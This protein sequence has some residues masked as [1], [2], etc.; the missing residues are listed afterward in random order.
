[1]NLITFI[2]EVLDFVFES[3]LFFSAMVFVF[4]ISVTITL[5]SSLVRSIKRKFIDREW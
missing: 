4:S 2:K 3:E 5:I 1:M